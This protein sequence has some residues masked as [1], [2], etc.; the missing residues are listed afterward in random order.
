MHIA[1]HMVGNYPPNHRH[2]FNRY[3]TTVLS[4]EAVASAKAVAIY[5]AVVSERVQSV[6]CYDSSNVEVAPDAK[7]KERVRAHDCDLLL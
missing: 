5:H 2:D 3:F 6:L 4:H 7:E 1:V